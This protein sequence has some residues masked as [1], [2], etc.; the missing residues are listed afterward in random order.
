[1]AA[2]VDLSQA[3]AGI[4]RAL[5]CASLEWRLTD[6][7]AFGLTTASPLQ[8]AICRVAD[9]RSLGELG[10]HPDVIRAFGGC[11]S[12]GSKPVELTILSGIRSGKSLLTATLAVHWTQACDLTALGPGEVPRVS[13]V[14][15]TKDLADVVFAHIVGR[16]QSSP[17]LRTLLVE[18][19]GSDSIVLR[20]PSGRPVEIKVVAGARAGAS[21]VARW[22]A[23]CIFD[24]FPRMTGE[25]DSVVNWNDS[26]DAVL[27][28]LLPGAQVAN[29]GSPWAPF[30]PA[31]AMVQEHWGKPSPRLVVVRAPAF[32]M[33]P[34][35]WTPERVA[36][37]ER[38]PDVYRTD[39][40]AEFAT[41][42]E[43]L[44][45]VEALEKST[46]D[47][48]V[49]CA[50]EAG[51]SYSAAMDPATRGNGWTLVV[52]TRRG[53]KKIVV[54]AREWLG[55]RHRP[56]NPAEVLVEIRDAVAAYGLD[57]V[58]SDQHMG[59]AL[60]AL[61]R[62]RGLRVHQWT[63]GQDE[64]T[65]RYLDIRTRLLSGEVE[66]PAVPQLRTDLLHLRKRITQAGIAIVLPE[67]SDGR[68]CDYAPSLMLSLSKWLDDERPAAKQEDAE[69]VKAREA[70]RRKWAAKE[71]DWS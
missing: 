66:L 23:G 46:R 28:R 59:D 25:G 47:A 60:V 17:L 22:S 65:R 39:V 53:K 15:L 33:N 13:I 6:P 9:G 42:E 43:A 36:D 62:D 51:L 49:E 18:P 44:F 4:Q 3:F 50:R 2:A 61:A 20:H 31:Y 40:L 12:L 55:S 30:G 69:T 34:V 32:A 67:T 63:L 19:P 7:L 11:V 1:M 37:A 56:L 16:V 29:I 48:P 38:D 41:P 5:A 35:H 52:S 71:N 10:Q 45:S 68:H 58:E 21:L 27:L 14:S 26:R 54:L 24:E 8:R 70:I 57:M 64:K